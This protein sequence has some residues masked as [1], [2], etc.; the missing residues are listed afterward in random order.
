MSLLIESIKLLDGTFYN[1]SYHE[2]RM[3]RSLKMLCGVSEPVDLEQFLSRFARPDKG[4]FKCR[5]EYDENSR[6]VQFLPYQPR[7]VDRLRIVAHDRI[8]YEFKYR[9]R[10]AIDRLYELR[11]DCD[12]ILIVRNG[13]ITDTAFANILFRRKN[14]W[15]TPWSALLKGTQRQ[16]LLDKNLIRAEDITLED[17]PAFQSFKLINAMVEFEGPEIDVSHIVL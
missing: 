12:D 4:L 10:R 8:N 2:Q 9:D 7:R 17:I 14:Q 11:K 15:I 16:Q 5:I 1:L 13:L 6:D 3:H